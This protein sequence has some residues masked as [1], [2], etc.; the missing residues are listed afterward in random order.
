MVLLTSHGEVYTCG[1]GRG[2][3]LGHGNEES[4]LV[5]SQLPAYIVMLDMMVCAVLEFQSSFARC[6]QSAF[7]FSKLSWSVSPVEKSPGVNK[8]CQLLHLKSL[9]KVD[10][11]TMASGTVS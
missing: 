1:H 5:C 7:P 2:G 4:Q 9:L 8:V 11:M 3:R 6:V 10:C